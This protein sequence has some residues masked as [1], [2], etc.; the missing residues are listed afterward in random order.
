[1]AKFAVSELIFDE[2][3]QLSEEQE[4]VD[5]IHQKHTIYID[6]YFLDRQKVAKRGIPIFDVNTVDGLV[7][8]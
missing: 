8:E 5:C 7:R 4:K 1:M 6:N 2:I 3:I